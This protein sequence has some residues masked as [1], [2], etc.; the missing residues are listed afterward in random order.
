PYDGR[1]PFRKSLIAEDACCCASE[2][3]IA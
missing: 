3:K 1:L 2:R